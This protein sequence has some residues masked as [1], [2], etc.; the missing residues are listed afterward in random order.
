MIKVMPSPTKDHVHQNLLHH[1][2][3]KIF[4][5]NPLKSISLGEDQKKKKL[6]SG[7]GKIVK[8]S[9]MGE[10]LKYSKG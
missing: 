10:S 7:G 4:E 1:K 9:I 5:S 6:Y 3:K 2:K 8:R